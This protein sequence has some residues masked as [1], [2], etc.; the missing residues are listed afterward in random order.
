MLG[1]GVDAATLVV[2]LGAGPP[3]PE[4]RWDRRP[5]RGA[6]AC[7]LLVHSHGESIAHLV[8]LCL[9]FHVCRSCFFRSCAGAHA[10]IHKCVRTQIHTP[11][12][13]QIAPCLLEE[14]SISLF[15]RW[16]ELCLQRDS[17]SDSASHT[18]SARRPSAALSGLCALERCGLACCGRHGVQR[19]APGAGEKPVA[20]CRTLVLFSQKRKLQKLC[21]GRWGP[22]PENV[23]AEFSS[24]L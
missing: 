24:N 21:V 16:V 2:A 4:C 14:Q 3:P 6:T 13:G 7:R 15:A 18:H 19:C 22:V 1:G 20:F 9:F 11:P 5:H 23:C 12:R 17:S 10:C 8:E